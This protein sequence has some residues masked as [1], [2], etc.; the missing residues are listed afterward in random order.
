[1]LTFASFS[2]AAQTAPV[3]ADLIKDVDG[4]QQKMVALA[5]AMP[6]EKYS[7]RPGTGVRSVSEVFLHVASDNYLMPALAG[8][9]IPVTTH[10][11][12][13]NFKSFSAF[14]TRTVTR[15]QAVGELEASFA[16]L[17]AAMQK[18]SAADMAKMVDMFGQKTTTQSMWVGATTHLHEHLGQSIAYA[19]MNGVVPPWSK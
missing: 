18:S 11:D 12:M 16:F 8:A 14:E 13:K 7:W 17:K 15:E 19:R 5:K 9:S 1:M 2:L 10:L 6:Q 4:V 3:V